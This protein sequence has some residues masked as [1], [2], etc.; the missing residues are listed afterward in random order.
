MLGGQEQA[1]PG[2]PECNAPHQFNGPQANEPCPTAE[3]E[4]EYAEHFRQEEE[5]DLFQE[6]IGEEFNPTKLVVGTKYV[7]KNEF[8]KH[9]R[10]FCVMNGHEFVWNKCDNKQQ[11]AVCVNCEKTECKFFIYG[12]KRKGEGDTFT[13]RGYN[14]EHNHQ[15]RGDGYNRSAIPPYVA[16]WYMEKRKESGCDAE[17]PCPYDLAAQFKRD[18]KVTIAY[19]TA[20]RARVMVLEKLYGSYEKSYQQVPNFCEM[21]KVML[22]L[23]LTLFFLVSCFCK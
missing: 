22:L 1:K 16:D 18:T 9:V 10:H 12:I 6:E 5:E 14:I 17:I 13:L 8:K 11:R 4:K 20:W 23:S 15:G 7:D 3:F 2:G 21:V 19:H